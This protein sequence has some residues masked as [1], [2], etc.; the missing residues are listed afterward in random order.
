MRRNL[1]LLALALTLAPGVLY[2][3]EKTLTLAYSLIPPYA[4][5]NLPGQGLLIAL[6]RAA[7]AAAGWTLALRE[8]P[9]AR[10]FM[11]AKEGRVDGIVEE[12]Y[13]LAYL[14]RM[15]G[16]PEALRVRIL[17]PS[18]GITNFVS[19]F[20]QKDPRA[21]EKREALNRGLEIIRRNGTY[22]QILKQ[23]SR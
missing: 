13:S 22:Q 18:L 17:E 10:V 9:A 5:K 12:R 11:E 20:T 8:V 4:D 15:D 6:N 7:L 16:S 3:Q 14:I 19:G 1:L 23:Y 21:G 2:S